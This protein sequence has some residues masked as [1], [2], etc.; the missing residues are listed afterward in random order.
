M[1]RGTLVYAVSGFY[2][3]L[4]DFA[5]AGRRTAIATVVRTQGSTPQVVGAK[6]LVTDDE[7][8]RPIGTLGGGCVEADAI[9]AAR[10]VLR[11]G[12]RTL[13]AY[14]R[15]KISP[16]ILAWCVAAR[17]GSGGAQRGRARAGRRAR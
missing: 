1:L 8:A 6:M 15:P 7:A 13:R 9:L 3:H 11:G 2:Q 17:C 12:D 10:D 14:Q 16:G 5:R 4:T